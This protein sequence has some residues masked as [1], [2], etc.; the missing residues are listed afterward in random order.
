MYNLYT[1]WLC[2]VDTR[3]W[4]GLGD[5]S[6]H[7][8]YKK[9]TE[10]SFPILQEANT[11]LPGPGMLDPSS[12]PAIHPTQTSGP[13]TFIV[14]Q[15]CFSLMLL[16]NQSC[17]MPTGEDVFFHRSLT[18]RHYS[19]ISEWDQVDLLPCGYITLV[20]FLCVCYKCESVT[21]D[22]IWLAARVC[23]VYPW[24][25]PGSTP[26]CYITDRLGN[27]VTDTSKAKC[28]KDSP[29]RVL[30][31]NQSERLRLCL[32]ESVSWL[33]THS[34]PLRQ[35]GTISSNLEASGWDHWH[36]QQCC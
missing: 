33:D 19:M 34:P 24:S 12:T 10:F 32:T 21:Y 35:R 31:K 2:L 22:N 5:K 6:T 29:S 23:V 18:E 11:G 13:L 30:R 28:N 7:L 15:L 1:V 4:L 25:H 8:V 3:M 16:G 17:I 36:T 9:R 26:L 20:L 14:V 27:G